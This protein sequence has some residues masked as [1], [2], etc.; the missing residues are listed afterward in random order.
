MAFPDDHQ[1]RMDLI[2]SVRNRSVYSQQK[3]RGEPIM[4]AIPF[5]GGNL[6][7]DAQSA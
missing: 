1:L 3:S 2:G 6:L 7:W 5:L 4:A